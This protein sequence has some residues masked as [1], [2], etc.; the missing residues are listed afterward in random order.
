FVVVVV[1]DGGDVVLVGFVVVLVVGEALF[2]VTAAGGDVT[3]VGCTTAVAPGPGGPEAE[4]A[5][6][7]TCRDVRVGSVLST[8]PTTF[9]GIARA[10]PVPATL[11]CVP[12][13]VKLH[14]QVSVVV[15]PDGWRQPRPAATVRVLV[16]VIVVLVATSSMTGNS[17]SCSEPLKGLSFPP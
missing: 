11:V 7:A 17:H 8:R 13:L 9:R 12:L 4:A 15:R 3:M 16:P 6:G 5:A 2:S 1:E 14:V 10:K